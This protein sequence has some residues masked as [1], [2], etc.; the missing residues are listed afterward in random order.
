M[1]LKLSSGTKNSISSSRFYSNLLVTKDLPGAIERILPGKIED[2]TLPVAHVDII[3]SEWMG[4]CLLFENMLPSVLFARDRYLSPPSPSQPGGLMIPSRTILFIAPF[5]NLE[6]VKDQVQYWDN[7]SGYDMRATYDGVHQ[8]VDIEHPQQPSHL[9]APAVPFLNLDLHTARVQ[10]LSFPAGHT[11]SFEIPESQRKH[12][13]GFVVW[14]D[15]FFNPS[16]PS[17]PAAATLASEV[18]TPTQEADKG[19]DIGKPRHFTT[20]PHGP[21]THWGQ[22][23]C[24][25]DYRT[26]EE[27][28]PLY[29]PTPPAN[30]EQGPATGYGSARDTIP[31]AIH[32]SIS[33][34]V[35]KDA[36]NGIDIGI[37]WQISP[38]EDGSE[39]GADGGQNG[40]RSQ[41]WF[42]H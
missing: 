34:T 28:D 25:I 3:I 37:K 17:I 29:E 10:D 19:V 27:K 32:G 24:L 8:D 1:L 42:L 11:F 31:K 30:R 41:V 35:P 6:Y 40:A 2:I 39:E 26:D 23:V 13:D 21:V 36:D 12:L 7:V 18:P 16:R 9:L 38:S 5:S 22:G 20:G 15:T 14:F 4:Y 33:Y